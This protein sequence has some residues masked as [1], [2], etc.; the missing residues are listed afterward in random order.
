MAEKLYK[1]LLE[2]DNNSKAGKNLDFSLL[3]YISKFEYDYGR[4]ILPKLEELESKAKKS[5][6]DEEKIEIIKELRNKFIEE[7]DN[8]RGN[9]LTKYMRIVLNYII[10]LNRK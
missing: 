1:S 7:I 4:N 5:K 9:F 6:E 2:I 3:T 10:Y 8:R